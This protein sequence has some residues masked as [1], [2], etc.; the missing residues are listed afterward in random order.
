M[1]C[2]LSG[3]FRRFSCS[4]S[5]PPLA[6]HSYKRRLLSCS[7][8]HG[9]PQSCSCAL[10]GPHA[11]FMRMRVPGGTPPPARAALHA[12]THTHA[13]LHSVSAGGASCAPATRSAQESAGS[14]KSNV[15]DNVPLQQQGA[16]ATKV[17]LY[18]GSSSNMIYSFFLCKELWDF[19]PT[20]NNMEMLKIAI[21]QRVSEDGPRG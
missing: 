13:H 8:P 5:P 10:P 1:G 20:V 2:C 7:P 16:R 3:C 21:A 12:H 11:C 6:K 4:V 14:P 17:P 18:L 9:A 19:F 15:S